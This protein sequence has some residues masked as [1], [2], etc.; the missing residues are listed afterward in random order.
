MHVHLN[1]KFQQALQIYLF[2]IQLMPAPKPILFIGYSATFLGGLQLTRREADH[3]LL[4]SA[5]G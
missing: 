4:S 5:E 1:V 2:S 3:P